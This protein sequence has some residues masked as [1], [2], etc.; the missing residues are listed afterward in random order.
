MRRSAALAATLAALALACA[1]DDEPPASDADDEPSAEQAAALPHYDERVAV[2]LLADSAD[3]ERLRAENS[4]DDFSVIADD[5]M[6]YRA[7]AIDWLETRGVPTVTV[8]RR[9]T[10]RFLVRGRVREFDYSSDPLLDLVV[11]YDHDRPPVAL[12]T[13]DVATEGERYFRTATTDP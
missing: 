6:W 13:V 2:L 12:A 1:R 11:L 3:I 10:L 4:E 5:L 7:E 9:D 8:T